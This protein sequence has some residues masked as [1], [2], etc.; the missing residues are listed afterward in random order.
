M[1]I[2]IGYCKRE[3]NLSEAFANLEGAKPIHT[4]FTQLVPFDFG[5]IE[6]STE[7]KEVAKKIEEFYYRDSSDTIHSFSTVSIK[8]ISPKH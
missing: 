4:S 2:I 6:D 1:P 8:I 5:L 3:G 7:A